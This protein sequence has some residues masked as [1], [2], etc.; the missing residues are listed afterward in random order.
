MRQDRPV[1]THPLTPLPPR[2]RRLFLHVTT[3]QNELLVAH[4]LNSLL[5]NNTIISVVIQ[6]CSE[7]NRPWWFTNNAP[8]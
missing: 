8:L 4:V 6:Y 1:R 3:Y 2:P 7:D 5:T